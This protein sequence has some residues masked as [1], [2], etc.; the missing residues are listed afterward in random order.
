MKKRLQNILAHRGIASR[1]RSAKLIEEGEVKVDGRTVSEKG[2]KFDPD[3]H[4]ITVSGK[5]LP[6]EEKKRYFLVNKPE[7]FIST[8]RDTHGRD[9]VTQITSDK[10]ERLYP[11]GRLDKETSGLLFMTNDGDLANMVMHPR[12]SIEKH[13]IAE[14]S[15][16]LN[17]T[18][19]KH[20]Q[21]GIDLDGKRTRRCKIRKVSIKKRTAKYRI[22]LCE[23]RKRQI[24]RMFDSLGS[25]IITL[26]RI[27]I[28]P[29]SIRGIKKGE[30]RE[31]SSNEVLALK[32]TLK[33][34]GNK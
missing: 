31:L 21:N 15:P 3:S 27:R 14:V 33:E 24:R 20:F 13:Y 2:R 25:G 10:E 29:L 9:I 5:K 11:V 23:G 19:L 1:R 18:Q 4:E 6:P 34:N 8:A 32:N 16:P 26:E 28:G 7:G 22:V 30:Y 12:Y 17:R